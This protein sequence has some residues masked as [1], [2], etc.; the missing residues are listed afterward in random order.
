MLLFL[1]A[2]F[3]ASTWKL[4]QTVL[5]AVDNYGIF[6]RSVALSH[7]EH[8]RLI[9]GASWETVATAYR[10]GKIYIF[11]YDAESQKYIQKQ[12]LVPT[13]NERVVFNNTG[14]TVE[15]SAD[16]R[17]IVAGAP[18]STVDGFAEVG[19][20]CVWDY[21]ENEQVFVQTAI[22]TPVAKANSTDAQQ[23]FGRSLAITTDGK[24]VASAYY[25]KPKV[26][27][28]IDDQG[29]VFVTSETS[30]GVWATPQKLMPSSEYAGKRLKFG[31]DLKFVDASHLVVGVTLFEQ[32]EGP[33]TC[34]YSKDSNNQWMLEQNILPD[35]VNQG[36]Y[37]DY[38]FSEY[39]APIGMPTQST[40]GIS[41]S[42]KNAPITGAFYLLN[43]AGDKWD[44]S[45]PQVVE[46]PQDVDLQGIS[47]CDADTFMTHASNVKDPVDPSKR[48]DAIIIY[49][50]NIDTGEFEVRG[51]ET[52]YPP[53][54]RP[55]LLN[56][57][58]DM[59]WSSDCSAVAIGAFTKYPHNESSIYNDQPSNESR[60]Y[61]YRNVYD[62][63]ADG[64][65]S[66]TIAAITVI[67]CIAVIAVVALI[68][69]CARKHKGVFKTI[70]LY[71]QQLNK[72]EAV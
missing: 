45:N 44:T 37:K 1:F 71:Q 60:V 53:Q 41:A 7:D 46:F 18:Y 20:L 10:V 5:P 25:N 48:T 55:D 64:L 12:E 62:P 57:G 47:Y 32:F 36:K 33:G 54:D 59:A 30:E 50:R 4:V 65:S 2:A 14:S 72:E 34:Y 56:F 68:V 22:I 24:T 28:F 29:A 15:I 6:G 3:S 16:G 23:G 26:Q 27:E 67:C 52:M 58:S 8:N 38:E 61:I 9:V 43:K 51:S 40:I 66:G 69:W 49:R 35:A 21:D 39:G 63:E 31:S 42:F 11:E 13:N 17:R 19:A 70:G